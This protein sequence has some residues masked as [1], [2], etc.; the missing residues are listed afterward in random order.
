MSGPRVVAVGAPPTFRQQ[1]AR[2]LGAAPESVEW[3]PTVTAAEDFMTDGRAQADLLALSPSVKAEDA[4][5][6]GEFVS[7][8][9]PATAV[10]VVRD[11]PPDG[12]LPSM[13]RSGIRDVVDLTN[14]GE[15]LRDSL[16]RALTWASSLRSVN[17]RAPVEDGTDHGRVVCVFSSKGGTGKTFLS[18]NL[19]VA[20]ARR[21]GEPTALVDLDVDLG[22]VFA[23]FGTQPSRPLQDLLSVGTD[24]DAETVRSLGNQLDEN[25]WGYGAPPDPGAGQ[26]VSAESV[27]AALRTLRR[28]FPFTILDGSAEYSDHVLAAMDLSDVIYLVTG[29][30]VVGLK[31]LSLAIQTLT[32]LGTPRE[33]VR[34]VLNRADSKVGI[35]PT[36]VERVMRIKPDVLVPSSSLVP[37]SLNHGVPVVLEEPR[38]AV[39]KAVDEL[40]AALVAESKPSNGAAPEGARGRRLRLAKH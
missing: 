20:I 3:V 18:C 5:G 30:D 7:R 12:A 38:S 37:A 10:V 36:D 39:A 9:S 13:I 40:A 4:I 6:F 22:D 24:V 27:G 8:R 16:H 28:F 15:D 19:A 32:T 23:Y 11:R 2:A 1:V 31:H 25:L 14:G 26:S 29:P 33:R 34:V 35:S 21:L 17:G